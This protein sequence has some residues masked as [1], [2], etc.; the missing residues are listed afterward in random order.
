VRPVTLT[1]DRID[2]L[3]SHLMLFYT[4]IKRTASDI[5]ASYDMVGKRRQLRIMKDLVD[6]GRSILNDD[7]DIARFGEL[8]HESW[9]AK[10]SLSPKVSNA[11]L[12][13]IYDLAR[14]NGAIGGKV[15]G[16]GGGGFMLLFV[17]PAGHR[18][19]REALGKLIYVPFKFEF[20]GSQIIFC[21]RQEDYSDLEKERSNQTID[22]FRELSAE[23][24]TEA[25]DL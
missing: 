18:Q 22:R 11:Q 16:A 6:E 1:Q 5:A 15:T 12:D 13:E 14:S 4:G 20:S 9:Q 2:E 10:R 8:L 3:N 19:V 24:P 7:E 25:E 17:P 23:R 21:D